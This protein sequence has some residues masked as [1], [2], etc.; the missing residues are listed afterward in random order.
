MTIFGH[1]KLFTSL[2]FITFKPSSQISERNGVTSWLS[3]HPAIERQDD[4]DD[5]SAALINLG[6]LL[7][8]AFAV[9]LVS[10]VTFQFK[11]KLSK[12]VMFFSFRQP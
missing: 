4:D 2:L 12:S 6:E 9:G 7:I 10:I 8:P 3:P 5:D 1:L 11:S